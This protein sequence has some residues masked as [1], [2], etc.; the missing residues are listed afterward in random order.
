MLPSKNDAP[1]EVESSS[2]IGEAF[3]ET[4]HLPA[5][6]ELVDKVWRKGLSWPGKKKNV[7]M[8]QM[9]TVL[10]DDFLKKIDGSNLHT[11]HVLFT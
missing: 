10:P 5:A 1:V 6:K 11:L 2:H 9:E 8:L 3:S 4:L 7:W